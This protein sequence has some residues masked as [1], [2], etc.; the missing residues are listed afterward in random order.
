MKRFAFATLVI[1][2][3]P[4]LT[5]CGHL[6]PGRA[7]MVSTGYVAHELCSAVFVAGRDPEPYYRDAIEPLGGSI[8]FLMKHVIDRDRSEVRA[9][10]AGMA[11]SRAIYRPPFGCINATDTALAGTTA[12]A[13]THDAAPP[14]LAPIADSAAVQT[15]NPALTTALERV[16]EEPAQGPHRNT[17]AVVVI[18]QDR[19]IAERYAPGVAIDTPLVGWSATKSVTNALLGI[20]VQQGKLDMNASAPIE[21]WADSQDPR[22]AITPDQL[23]RMTSGLDMGQ[24]LHDVSPFDPA[25]QMLFIEHDMAAFAER[26]PLAHPPGTHWNYTDPNTLLL[27]RIVRHLAGGDMA[28]TY[29]FVHRE[30]FDK[31]GMQHATLEFDAA[32]TPVGSSQMWASARDWAKFGLLYLHDGVVGGE[33]LLP[34]GWVAYSA[35]Q[36]PGGEYVGYGAGFWTNRGKGYGSGYRTQAGIPADAF[37]AR[38]SYGQYVVIIPSEQLIIARF[39][40]AWT[41][42]DDMDAVARLTREVIEALKQHPVASNK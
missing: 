17:Q 11:Q 37:M 24:T 9:T 12:P 38:G 33:R 36:T 16:F 15:T 22:H 26:A 32:G 18:H 40:P 21:A 20:L 10:F 41:P 34:P 7:A 42:R 19:I 6:S 30:L 31:L 4:F 5:A 35:R 39:G 3:A 25:A 29:T 23:L 2:A 14:L 13:M 28:S 1:A 27:S 8:A